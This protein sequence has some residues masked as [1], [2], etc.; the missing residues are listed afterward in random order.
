[1]AN[2]LVAITL[3]SSIALLS[4][5]SV[6]ISSSLAFYNV[7][8]FGAKPDGR[9]DSTQPFL[10]AWMAACSSARPA[11]VYVPR[12]TFLIR[13]VTFNGPCR[14]RIVFE[15]D[16]TL[17]APWD[18]HVI[19]NTGNWIYFKQ[20]SWVSVHGGTI[21][22]R[23]AGFWACRKTSGPCPAGA[24]SITFLASNNVEINGLRSINSQVIHVAIA[25]CNNV[26]IQN[27]N[28]RASTS[29]LNTDG[30]HVESSTGV[31]ITRSAFRTGDDC[32]SIGPATTNVWIQRIACGP[33][34]GISIGSLG[35][36]L[37]EGG[38]QNVTV[39][40]VVFTGTQNGVR[41]KT[42][43]RPSNGFARDIEFRNVRM[44][45]VGN[46]IIIDQEYC[47]NN[48]CPTM[49]S[50]VHVSQVTYSNIKG[51]SSTPVAV[52]FNCSPSVP[53]RGIQMKDVQL[54]FENRPATAFCA[55]ARG[56]SSGTVIPKSCL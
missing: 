19:G 52:T 20:V 2:K 27:L 34:H 14:N 22:A 48:Q 54:T 55:N 16:G 50:G 21:D 25:Q 24:R 32:I 51:T 38:V 5:I 3:L 30:I 26:N 7:V 46:P 44:K 8:S 23:G 53:C 49:S 56:T 41:I 18:Y 29:S 47:P 6:T 12:G 13:S 35:N 31:T 45:N 1:M 9:T 36:G 42:W 39:T 11:M 17:V 43:A 33:G 28:V 4:C 40:G 37:I 15:I 10:R